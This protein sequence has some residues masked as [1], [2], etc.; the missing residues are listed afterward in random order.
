MI[1]INLV[2]E[3]DTNRDYNIFCMNE[4]YQ[5][6]DVLYAIHVDS[7]SNVQSVDLTDHYDKKYDGNMWDMNCTTALTITVCDIPVGI[8]TFA[9]KERTGFKS[10][11]IMIQEF[12]IEPKYRNILCGENAM[13]VLNDML[14]KEFIHYTIQ[15][16]CQRYNIRGLAFYNKL[17][18]TI[19]REDGYNIFHEYSKM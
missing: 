18:F 14:E 12:F 4:L 17:G 16:T 13:S 11:I 3:Y 10:I 2:S 6:L 7:T 1:N 5:Y 15:L 8:I 9:V 19:I